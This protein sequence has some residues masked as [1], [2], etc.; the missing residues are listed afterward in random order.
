M[1]DDIPLGALSSGPP[2]WVG[3]LLAISGLILL[4]FLGWTVLDWAVLGW[5][6][7]G[8][9]DWWA[10]FIFMST[11]VFHWGLLCRRL[12]INLF[13]D[14]VLSHFTGQRVHLDLLRINSKRRLPVAALGLASYILHADSS[15]WVGLDFS[16]RTLEQ[17]VLIKHFDYVHRL[18]DRGQFF[19]YHWV[20]LAL[21]KRDQVRLVESLAIAR[22]AR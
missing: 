6:V 11:L 17:T 10:Q 2:P 14:Q 15:R 20:P 4:V 8:S 5:T 13:L 19:L 22:G 21:L 7:L 18:L 1:F 12:R 9:L 16:I 3:I